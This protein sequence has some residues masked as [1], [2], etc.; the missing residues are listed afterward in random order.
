[1]KPNSPL[2]AAVLLRQLGLHPNRRLSQNFLQDPHALETISAAARIESTDTVLEIGC[3]LGSLTRQLASVARLVVAVELD[4]RLASIA[5]DILKSHA[6]VRII[7]GD[8]LKLAPSE[9]GL[10]SGYLVAANI[11]YNITSTVIRHLLESEPKPRRVVLTV[12]QEVAE[13]V[14]SKPP[15]MSVLALSVQVYAAAEIV[16]KI[17]AAAFFPVPQVDSAIVRM[18]VYREPRIPAPLLPVFFRLVKAGFGQKRKT[19]RNAIASGTGIS[20]THAKEMLLRVGIDPQLRAEALDISDWEKLCH[21]QEFHAGR[22]PKQQDRRA[23]A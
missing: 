11:P 7:S 12:Q 19:L 3:G 16:A 15:D 4:P 14:C 10:P 5:R 21:L 9:L 17:P 22:G 18:E 23:D 6:N 2:D 1:M 13:R 20:A 8:I